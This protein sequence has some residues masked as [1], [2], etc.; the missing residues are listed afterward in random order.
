M[1]RTR[2][3]RS[4]VKEVAEHANTWRN[5]MLIEQG[6]LVEAI[7]AI[8]QTLRHYPEIRLPVDFWTIDFSE[9]IAK[10]VREKA[11]RWKKRVTVEFI[12]R[13]ILSECDLPT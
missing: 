4:L 1:G 7:T 5:K 8:K 10:R 3:P 11:R 6:R 2:V 12:V 9:R 13:E